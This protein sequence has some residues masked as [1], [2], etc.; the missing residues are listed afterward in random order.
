MPVNT[1]AENHTCKSIK[2]INKEVRNKLSER[3]IRNKQKMKNTEDSKQKKD[4]SDKNSIT[5]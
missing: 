2:Q 4:V 1:L 5:E 3:F